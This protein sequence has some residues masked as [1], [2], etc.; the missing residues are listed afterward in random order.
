MIFR[1][2]T[3]WLQNAD[4]CSLLRPL[5]TQFKILY[6]EIQIKSEP[7]AF[8]LMVKMVDLEFQDSTWNRPDFGVGDILFPPCIRL[9]K[10]DSV[11]LWIVAVQQQNKGR[12]LSPYKSCK[13]MRRHQHL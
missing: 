3:N 6:L 13:L 2:A 7:N 11:E 10:A 8:H 9:C 4:N 5:N 12:L 1:E